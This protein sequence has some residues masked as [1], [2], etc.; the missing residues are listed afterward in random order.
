MI[1]AVV[2]I[3]VLV[4]ALIGP[5]GFSSRV[6]DA[7]L[8]G[9]FRLVTAEGI[10]AELGQKLKMPRISKWLK[11]PEQNRQ[12][13]NELL[14]TEAQIILIPLSEDRRV[15]GDP[16]DDYVLATTRLSNADYLITGDKKLLGLLEYASAKIVSP[17]EFVAILESSAEPTPS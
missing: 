4:S 8:G 1:R 17:R 12:K 5:L 14:M 2:D 15:T 3:N 16:E 6:V 11:E 7:W 10:I 13:I 9:R